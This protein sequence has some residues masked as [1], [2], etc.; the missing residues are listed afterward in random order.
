MK[1]TENLNIFKNL[2][3]SASS[4]AVCVV[5]V[6]MYTETSFIYV[7]LLIELKNIYLI[8]VTLSI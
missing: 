4:L 2:L 3:E 8:Y 6:N 1:S 5:Y 7:R